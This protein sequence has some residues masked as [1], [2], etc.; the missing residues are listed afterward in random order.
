MMGKVLNDQLITP[1]EGLIHH[2][3]GFDLTP[4]D[5]QL[6]G[7]EVDGGIAGKCYEP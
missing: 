5:I 3:E 6:S 4:A 7:M 1:G 2:P